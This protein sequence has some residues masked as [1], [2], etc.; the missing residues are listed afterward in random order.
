[1]HYGTGGVWE[2]GLCK[3]VCMYIYTVIRDRGVYFPS[4]ALA[5]YI[6]SRQE[7]ESFEGLKH[8]RVCILACAH[9]RYLF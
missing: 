4:A 8:G 1:M 2:C 3:R 6:P 7:I 5:L 9:T